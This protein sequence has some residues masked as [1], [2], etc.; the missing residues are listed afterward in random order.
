MTIAFRKYESK[1]LVRRLRTGHR[2][3]RGSIMLL[4]AVM[5]TGMIGLM[6]LAI[7]LGF[8]F[9]SRNQ[10]QNGIDSAVLAAASALRATIEADSGMPQQATL[11][12][13]LAVQFAG[14][15]QVRRYA[16]PDPNSGTPNANNIVLDPGS[17]SIDASSDIPRIT[18][19]TSL[20]TPLLFG[21]MFGFNSININTIS[22]ASVFP[23]DGG[24]GTIGSC[25]RPLLIPDTFYDQNNIVRYVGDPARGGT[26]LPDQNG[27]YYR[28]RFAVGARNLQPFMDSMSGIGNS[29]TGLRDIQLVTDIGVR[30]IMGQDVIFRRDYYRI[31]DFSGLPRTTFDVLSVGDLA[32][33]GYCGQIRVGDNIPVFAP[34]DFTTYDQVRTGLE[35][36]RLRSSDSVDT[37]ARVGYKYIKSSTY[38]NPNS[39]RLIIPVLLFNPVELVRNP[40]AGILRVTNFGLFFLDSVDANGNLSGFFVREIITGGTPIDSTNFSGDSDPT[41]KRSWLPMSVHLLR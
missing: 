38:P 33:F 2:R 37:A 34:N 22:S 35:A 31:A 32:N 14:Y 23:V 28:S 18:I 16:D 12:R 11:A 9:S 5:L 17:V 1:S 40:S 3:Q 21:G 10:F 26:P 6:A 7:D 41:F 8:L 20:D 39:H 19:N 27:D 30:S 29:A 13:E 4:T 24:T 15:N 25:W 36:L